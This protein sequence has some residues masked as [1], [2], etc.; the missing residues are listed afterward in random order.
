MVGL[1]MVWLLLP[2][3]RSEMETEPVELAA[4]P[5]MA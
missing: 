5:V 2:E 4:E 1:A 3:T